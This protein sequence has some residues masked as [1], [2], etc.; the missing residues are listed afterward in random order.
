VKSHRDASPPVKWRVNE[1]DMDMFGFNP[2][3]ISFKSIFG[4]LF[5]FSL[6]FDSLFI[7]L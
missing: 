4:G 5:Y 6:H 1:G 2:S 7:L 3:A